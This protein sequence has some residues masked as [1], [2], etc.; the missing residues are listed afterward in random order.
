MLI[1]RHKGRDYVAIRGAGESMRNICC[2]VRSVKIVAGR[3]LVLYDG[4][5]IWGDG[6]TKTPTI[7]WRY[8][9]RTVRFQ[10]SF[11]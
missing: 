7:G 10:R 4:G 6:Q 1:S 11:R 2:G 8:Q 3:F 5:I 9:V